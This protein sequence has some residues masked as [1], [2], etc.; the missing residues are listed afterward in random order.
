MHSARVN[1]MRRRQQAQERINAQLDHHGRHMLDD[2][3]Q[4][5]DL[6]LK[7]QKKLHRAPRASVFAEL[8]LSEAHDLVDEYTT[9]DYEDTCYLLD[10]SDPQNMYF[11]CT[12]PPLDNDNLICEELADGMDWICR[13]RDAFR[14]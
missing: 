11:M 4:D 6:I 10:S 12:S 8:S 1:A 14:P 5:D 7:L 2:A 3:T 13:S 9:S